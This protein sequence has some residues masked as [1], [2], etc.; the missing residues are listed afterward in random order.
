MGN[1]YVWRTN[2]F[3]REMHKPITLWGI[4]QINKSAVV[5]ENI[6]FQVAESNGID[7]NMLIEVFLYVNR[8]SPEGVL[9]W[10]RFWG[11]YSIASLCLNLHLHHCGHRL[12]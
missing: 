9:S 5:L 7:E 6:L 10:L 11:A 2:L 12:R 4:Y 1:I 3:R 8:A